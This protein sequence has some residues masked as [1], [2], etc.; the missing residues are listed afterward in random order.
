LALEGKWVAADA[1]GE[2]ISRLVLRRQRLNTGRQHC[3]GRKDADREK[4]SRLRCHFHEEE[5]VSYPSKK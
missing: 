1:E 2:G 4:N 3:G 5:K